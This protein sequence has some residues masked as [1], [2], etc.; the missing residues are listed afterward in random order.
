MHRIKLFLQSSMKGVK[1]FYRNHPRQFAL[2]AILFVMTSASVVFVSLRI[3]QNL[4]Y[5][6]GSVAIVAI[7]LP[8]SLRDR[9]IGGICG[10][11]NSEKYPTLIG[12]NGSRFV[13]EKVEDEFKRLESVFSSWY[14][15]DAEVSP[16][17]VQF[18]FVV[19]S[20]TP[21]ESKKNFSQLLQAIAEKVLRHQFSQFLLHYPDYAALTDV[22]YQAPYLSITYARNEK[23]REELLNLKEQYRRMKYEEH[24]P[25]TSD[26]LIMENWDDT[27]DAASGMIPYGYDLQKFEEYSVKQPIWLPLESHPHALV[28]GSSGSGK[29][30]ALVY[31]LGKLLQAH[32]GIDLWLCDFKNSEDFAFL[33]GH[34]HYYTGNQCYLGI[35]DYYKAFTEARQAGQISCRHI[36]IFDEYPSCVLYFQSKDKQEKTKKASEILSAVSEI[37][38]L[39]RGINYGIWTVCQRASASIFPE[40]SRDNYMVSLSLGRMSKEQKGMLFPG[41]EIPD[42][43]CRPGEGVLLADGYPLQIVKFPLVQDTESWERHIKSILGVE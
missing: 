41:E 4:G 34:P 16:N 32:P 37:L 15:T 24:H 42:R 43:I 29:S 31:L 19:Y 36:L 14:F 39:G 12:Y 33:D 27:P 2:A 28:V 17:H 1:S 20:D 38:M 10:E 21:D 3:Y 9:I 11:D 6:L 5:V 35:T 26:S 8:E 23:G 18:H 22:Q 13:P 25:E 30:K 7:L 40:G